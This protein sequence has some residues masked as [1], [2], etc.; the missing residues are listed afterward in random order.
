MNL[1]WT[2]NWDLRTGRP[3][4]YNTRPKLFGKRPH[5]CG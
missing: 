1:A 2:P 4:Q 3:Q 5:R